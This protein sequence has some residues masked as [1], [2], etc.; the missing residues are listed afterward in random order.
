[1]TATDSDDDRLTYSLEGTD[2]GIFTLASTS[3]Q[4]RTR[5]GVT[6]DYE[7][8]PRYS[9]SVKA[10]DGHGGS[11]TIPVF[12]NLNDVNEPPAF[13]RDAAFEAA[14]NQSLAGRV[15]AEDADNDDSITGYTLTGGADRDLLEINSAGALTFKNAPNFEDPA[16]NG[17]NNSYIVVIT[18]TGGTGGRALTA[19]QTIT[20]TVTNESEPPGKP[21]APTLTSPRPTYLVIR[22]TAPENSG[23]TPITG[24]DLRSRLDGKP[25]YV[26]ATVT[27]GTAT[28]VQNIPPGTAVEVQVRAINDDG[29]GEWSDS[30]FGSV[31][32]NKLPTFDEASPVRSFAEN[33]GAGQD[34]GEPLHV[35]D[36]Y[37]GSGMAFSLEGTDAGS[38]DIV[39]VSG[40]RHGQLQTKEGVTY[41]YETKNS[42][43]VT[44][45]VVDPQGGIATVDATIELIGADEPPGKPGTPR[46]EAS[47]MTSLTLGWTAP[48]NTGRPA[49]SGYDVQY[50]TG[51]GTFTVV[52]YDGTDTRATVGSLTE[53]TEYE[54]QVRA[55]NADG[56]GGWSDP[57]RGTTSD[58]QPPVFNVDGRFEVE[59][60][61]TTAGD[62]VAD[63]ADA[64]D[65][66]TGYEITGGADQ[67]QFEIANGNTL[68]FRTAP[69]FDRPA[70]LASTVPAS[71]AGDND[72]IVEIT[73]T[74]G[75]GDRVKTTALPIVVTVTN[76]LEPPG[77]IDMPAAS[78]S[79]FVRAL[80]VEWSVPENDGPDIDR[81]EVQYRIADSGDAF[82]TG[83]LSFYSTAADQKKADVHYLK[84]NT[85]YEVQVRGANAEGPGEW[86]ESAFGATYNGPP[87]VTP[88]GDRTLTFEGAAEMV[89]LWYGF[90]DGQ[91]MAWFAASSSD[92]A[93]AT[94]RVAGS[95]LTIRPVAVGNA[96]I[97]ITGSDN[98]GETAAQTIDVTVQAATLPDPT[99][100]FDADNED[101]AIRFTDRFEAGETRAYDVR[102]RQQTPLEV[103]GKVRVGYKGDYITGCIEQSNPETGAADISI[104]TSVGV[105][106]GT[107]YEADYRYRG[108][109]CTER[110]YSPGPWSRTVEYTTSGTSAFDVEFVFKNFTPT[111]AK[112]AVFDAAEA[113][114]E[115]IIRNSL[116]D[117]TVDGEVVDDLR[118]EVELS[119]QALG[120]AAANVKILRFE[121]HLPA[122]SWMKFDETFYGSLSDE[123][124]KSV[125]LH[126]MAHALGFSATAHRWKHYLRGRRKYDRIG[127]EIPDTHFLGPLAIAAFD[128][129]GGAD[130]AGA[131]APVENGVTRFTSGSVDHHW[132]ESVLG[133]ELMTSLLDEPA[134]L[135]AVTVQALADIGY[136]VDV[137]Q[138]DPYTLPETSG[139]E[140]AYVRAEAAG[141]SGQAILFRCVHED[142]AETET[143][144]EQD[145]FP[146]VLESTILEIRT[147]GGR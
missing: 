50:R 109:P 122:V 95:Y 25:S 21:D 82:A 31:Q 118:I 147:L 117:F 94:V 120:S 86:S 131:K 112:K 7:T 57:V 12:V 84:T 111:A 87:F 16:D 119:P 34:V 123:R 76:V 63:D 54:L 56:D 73:A 126:E 115:R 133:D 1:M 13:T 69:D 64:E 23:G 99:A 108:E 41:D 106:P 110:D 101:L 85:R 42:Y 79:V 124:L 89:P 105:E 143:V 14:E 141:T 44:V 93:V 114:W 127:D 77:K 134:P 11:S 146:S 80:S 52:N 60:N 36:D 96:S 20:V 137:T 100:A 35:T 17:R 72:Y 26:H 10:E 46:V 116:P 91:D 4:L 22:W 58:N 83:R 81:Y 61:E 90:R 45:K 9:V 75:A 29:P 67:D 65:S 33:T 47:T 18:V 40:G 55:K 78:A 138:A 121:S 139:S 104:V 19:A 66:I 59:E 15:A 113:R 132:R 27:T 24:Y 136:V 98:Y 130:Y 74:S 92:D 145:A 43:S 48:D 62:V 49:I 8:K 68:G 70:D 38:F 53:N 125:I 3:G 5:S 32:P 135:S 97:E 28:T 2:A 103:L 140:G 88:L 128:D 51:A 39:T 142:P 107:T 129:A 37:I 102:V 144:E 30:G 71:E 6:Y